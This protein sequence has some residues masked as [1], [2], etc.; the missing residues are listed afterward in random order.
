MFWT[1]A[2]MQVLWLFPIILILFGANFMSRYLYKVTKNPYIAGI[3]NGV[4]VTIMT[5]TNTSTVFLQ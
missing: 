4:I 2:A 1:T 5:V 3:V